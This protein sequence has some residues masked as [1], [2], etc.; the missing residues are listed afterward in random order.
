MNGKQVPRFAAVF[1]AAMLLAGVASASAARTE[2]FVPTTVDYPGST[3][4]TARGINNSGDIVGTY[5]CSLAAG[6]TLT[7]EEGAAG[8]HGFLLQDGVY[9]RID[10]PAEGR[11]ATNA[12]GIGEH[13]VIVGHYTA[14]GV[15]HGFA[16][17]HG[18]Y[19]YPIDVPA[20]LFDNPDSPARH[21]LPVRISPRGDIVGCIHEGNAI[22][23]TMHG[24]LLRR[25]RFS[26]LSTP[27]YA[28]DTTSRDPDTMNNGIT[29]SGE[30]V[31]FY[32]SSGVSY[33]ADGGG[34]RF[35]FTVEG[36]RFTLAWDVNARGDI[37]GVVGE[38]QANT[39]GFA[40]NERGFLRNRH[41]EYRI[42]EAQ[43]ASS[44]QVIGI[45]TRREIVGQYTDAATGRTH[46]F[47]Y[48]LKRDRRH[49]DEREDWNEK[50]RDER[51]RNR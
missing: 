32:F 3:S 22:M 40:V 19:M 16:Y 45:N 38:N 11:T 44:T 7:G 2:T 6:C 26:V 28:G 35:T 14:A 12:R 47:V 50:D 30:I 37:V 17:F 25:G 24:F 34:I 29:P 49:N 1:A 36:D 51:D 4:T 41:G 42:L 5:A 23:T 48:R 31:G 39:V 27:H 10:V 43:G 33:V 8:L 15:Q 21:T 20:E 9:T 46:G 13:G 18:H